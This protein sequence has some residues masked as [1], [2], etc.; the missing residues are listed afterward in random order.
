M[1]LSLTLDNAAPTPLYHQ[2]Y[3][4]LRQAILSRR[5]APGDRL[6]STRDLANALAVSRTTVTVAY[7]QLF[8]EG[9]LVARTGA[10]TFVSS[11][12]P[13]ALLKPAAPEFAAPATRPPLPL[14]A[15]GV[16][17]ASAGPLR[18]ASHPA[19]I[20]F[21]HY[22]RPA[23]DEFPIDIWRRLMLRH[24]RSGR[25]PLGYTEDAQGHAP[26][27]EALATYLQRSRAVRCTP[28]QIVIVGGSQ[29][30]LDLITR[31]LVDAGD[32][33]ALEEPG[34]LGARHA[35]MTAGAQLIPVPVDDAGL[36]VD[37]LPAG[38]KLVHVTPSHQ[39]P[40]GVVLSLPR[41]LALL[42]WARTQGALI[43]EDDYDSEFRY[44]DRPIPSLQGLDTAGVVLYVGT[45]SKILFPALR[46]GY[47]VVPPE[48]APLFARAKWL[49]DRQSP[50]LEQLAL[51]DF[52][53]EGH[54]ERHLRRM[55]V[56]YEG[57][58]RCLL[59]AL[60]EHLGERVTILGDHA[61]L[62]VTIR[63]RTHLDGEAIAQRAAA[64]GV[65][66]A[67]TRACYMGNPEETELVLGY[68]DLDERSI[69][70]GVRR[71]A[72]ALDET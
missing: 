45:F 46:L 13:D 35:F 34:Y 14:S 70:V 41:R 40:T 72:A 54:L 30:G 57:R 60:H 24:A 61:G 26:L 25:A 2:L 22:G 66:V 59:Q 51:T 28:E 10:G 21:G 38:V 1:E 62:H 23:L 63:L 68:A 71:L 8:A 7:D 32:G 55:R 15:Y 4:A 47:M 43:V 39:F 9:Y 18:G 65:G 48:W 56:L 64:L 50:L 5:L 3:E 52:I 58:R 29:Q 20:T 16:R 6:P 19:A 11:E 17:L 27:R 53:V 37:Q 36:V 31:L 69:E 44:G 12:L 42:D 49:A 67:T 33:V